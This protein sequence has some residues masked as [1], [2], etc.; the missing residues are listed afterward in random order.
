MNTNLLGPPDAIRERLRA[1]R[2]AGISTLQAKLSGSTTEQLD[3]LGQL[4][5]LAAELDE[6]PAT[7][8]SARRQERVDD[9]RGGR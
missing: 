3:T 8:A 7:A 9:Q 6:P 1:Y 2:R 4:I 5:D